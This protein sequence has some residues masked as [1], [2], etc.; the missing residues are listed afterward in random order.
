MGCLNLK[1][2]LLLILELVEKDT[3][4][5]GEGDI[6]AMSDHAPSSIVSNPVTIPVSPLLRSFSCPIN[7]IIAGGKRPPLCSPGRVGRATFIVGFG[8]AVALLTF[9][10]RYGR[11]RT[12]GSGT[13]P[14]TAEI[15]ARLRM[16][17]AENTKMV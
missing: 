1:R 6:S 13:I 16:H 15:A 10:N 12:T 17:S 2:L 9:P 14:R 11:L 5:R 7:D 4:I 8:P 3:A